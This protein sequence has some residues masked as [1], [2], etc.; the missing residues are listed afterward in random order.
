MNHKKKIVILGAGFGGIRASVLIAK[1][2]RALGL[3]ERYEVLLID[4]NEHHTYTPLL[5][6]TATTSK[7]TADIAHLHAI[8]AHHVRRLTRSL[9]IQFLQAEAELVD[10]VE[11]DI[12]LASGEKLTWNY[13]VIA[14]GSEINFFGIPGAERYSLPLK[15]FADAIRIRDAIWNRLLT[16]DK[17]VRIAVGGGGTTGV[18]IAGEL[19]AWAGELQDVFPG[20]RL[21]VRIIE[22]S[23]S[24]LN[25]F[26][27]RV[28]NMVR[29]RLAALGVV[30]TENARITS[31][32][33]NIAMIETGNPIPFDLL[34]W[35][36][37]VKAP[38]IFGTM[39]IK[40]DHGRIEV[41]GEMTCLPQTPDL[42]LHTT[43]YALGDSICFYD[44][45]TKKPIPSVARAALSQARIVAHNLIEDIK[46]EM[47][48]R[49]KPFHHTYRPMEYPYIIPVGGKYAVAKL[50]PFV[51][52]GFFGWALKGLVEL[53]YL[54]SIMPLSY[55][56]TTWWRGLMAFIKN[57][58]L[59]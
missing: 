24:I 50:G 3:I 52:S 41:P 37:G 44:P 45:I 29:A 16:G 15:T 26:D 21:S 1:Q 32:E 53:N 38:A 4:R 19:T 40:E 18:E 39:P 47:N 22:A 25:G 14:L 33:N 51:I 23:P 20:A 5:Y 11:G 55:A 8:V 34:L 54:L 35:T 7:E 13:L 30:I 46:L 43:I 49:Y 10:L 28:I 17:E 6:E 57:D 2:L 12:H 27:A 42:K 59:G 56:L 31:V 36:A 9:P 58:R 48:P